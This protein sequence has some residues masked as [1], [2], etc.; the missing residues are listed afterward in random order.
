MDED[1]SKWAKATIE[2]LEKLCPISIKVVYEQLKRGKSLSLEEV[3]LMEYRIS[4]NFM[5]GVDFFEGVRASLID[6]D[7]SPKWSHES[8][9]DVPDD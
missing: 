9:F 6:K 1:E 5:N 4:Q 8:I 2:S 3:F 7:K